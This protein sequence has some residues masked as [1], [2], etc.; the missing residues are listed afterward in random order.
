MLLKKDL[1]GAIQ[2]ALFELN[3]DCR[4]KV[5]RLDEITDRRLALRETLKD[6]AARRIC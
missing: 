3:N 5:E 1:G 6:R 2:R 4:P